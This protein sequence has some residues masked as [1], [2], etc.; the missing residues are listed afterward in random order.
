MLNIVR[1][2]AVRKSDLSLELVNKVAMFVPVT[3]E[4]SDIQ[5]TVAGNVNVDLA[6]FQLAAQED[7]VLNE[8]GR[9][10]LLDRA[11]LGLGQQAVIG[12]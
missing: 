1:I 4:S 9:L 8:R 12:C 3:L 2:G 7:L 6:I 11:E 5:L 10:G